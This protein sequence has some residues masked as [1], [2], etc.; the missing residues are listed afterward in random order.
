MI[1]KSIRERVEILDHT[2]EGNSKHT[3]IVPTDDYKTTRTILENNSWKIDSSKEL[4]S[5]RTEIKFSV[6]GIVR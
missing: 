1:V 5:D 4:D 3:I 6:K 2:D